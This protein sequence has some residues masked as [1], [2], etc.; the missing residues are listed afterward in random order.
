[1]L[2][3]TIDVSND[4]MTATGD[5]ELE[6]AEARIERTMRR[7][8]YDTALEFRAIRDARLYRQPNRARARGWET[9]A[10]YCEGRWARGQNA[11]DQQ[12][13]RAIET[14]ETVK[15]LTISSDQAPSSMSHA[16]ELSKLETPEQRAE[17][18][19]RVLALD[20]PITAAVVAAERDKY[21]AEQSRDWYTLDAWNEL[22]ADERARLLTGWRG[23][24]KTFN[25]QDSDNIEWARWS[26]NPVTGC[27]HNCDYCYARDIAARF[28][29]Q[30]FVPSFLPTRLAAPSNT[31]VP[32]EAERDFGYRNVFVCSMADLFGK[33]V[34]A[35]WIEAV[36]QQVRDN[37]QWTFL[38]LT[39]FPIRMAEFDYPPNVWLGTSV[40]RQW[41]VERA[42]KAFVKIKASGFSGVCWL[43]CEPMLE[44]LTFTSLGMFDWVVMGGSSKST[45]TAEYFPPSRDI[46]HLANQADAAG[47]R[48]YEKTNLYGD[49][50]RTREYPA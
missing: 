24:N 35:E 37:P 45:Q 10:E 13:A 9:W 3:M 38:F 31:H 28:Y 19:R 14:A 12:I 8:W 4:E 42:E 27:L 39:K 25:K 30:N 26:W 20:A 2:D 50:G 47:C 16:T 43:S 11:L 40:D 21:T 44:R 1:M 23:S 33:W 41:A 15:I 18:W 7:A 48:I 22:A 6:A 17:V 46:R 49:A 34:P 32:A 29:P 5:G 36:L